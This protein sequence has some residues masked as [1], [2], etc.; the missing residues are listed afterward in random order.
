MLNKHGN[1]VRLH[2][3]IGQ[4]ELWIGTKGELRHTHMYSHT[5]THT[6]THT[7]NQSINQSINRSI[8]LS[9]TCIM[10][11]CAYITC[12]GYKNVRI[13]ATLHPDL[14]HRERGKGLVYTVHTEM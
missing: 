6:H 2:F 3:K 12:I 10:Y 5:C 8:M 1:K 13:F 14:T 9:V 7:H 4:E 11:N